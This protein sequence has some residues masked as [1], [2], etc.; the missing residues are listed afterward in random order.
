MKKRIHMESGNCPS[1][2]VILNYQAYIRA[3]SSLY[4]SYV[5]N[6]LDSPG[7]ALM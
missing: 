6:F 4:Q 1:H 3:I 5:L 2:F 7:I